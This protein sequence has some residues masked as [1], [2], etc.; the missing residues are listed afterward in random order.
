MTRLFNF[1]S[2]VA[3]HHHAD[4]KFAHSG[5]LILYFLLKFWLSSSRKRLNLWNQIHFRNSTAPQW[6]YPVE[7]RYNTVLYDK[8][9]HEWLQKLGQNI[10]HML[11]PY[12]AQ[13]GELWG[14]FCEYFCL[15]WP[16]YNGT[17]HYLEIQT[18]NAYQS[19]SYNSNKNILISLIKD[20]LAMACIFI[21]PIVNLKCFHRRCIIDKFCHLLKADGT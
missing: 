5:V 20:I 2:N 21:H 7:C 12:L 16:G 11:T 3:I 15:Y 19:Y 18:M 6:Y 8:V 13:T 4:S 9:L 17:P 14:V 1:L 10:N